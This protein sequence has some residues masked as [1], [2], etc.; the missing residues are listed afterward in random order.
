MTNSDKLREKGCRVLYKHRPPGMEHTESDG[1]FLLRLVDEARRW[2]E[3]TVKKVVDARIVTCVYCGHE[4]PSGAPASQDA[5]LTE[6][7]ST[8]EKHPIR[9]VERDRDAWKSECEEDRAI[10]MSMCMDV[11]PLK[12][13]RARINELE[14]LLTGRELLAMAAWQTGTARISA[15]EDALQEVLGIVTIVRRGGAVPHDS[16]DRMLAKARAALAAKE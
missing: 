11:E 9:A 4:Y 12:K 6:H 3:G 16:V 10:R 15:L 8:C 1:E 2:A 14:S 13:A 7:I 5:A